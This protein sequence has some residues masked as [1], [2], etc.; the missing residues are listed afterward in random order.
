M[1]ERKGI[2]LQAGRHDPRCRSSRAWLRLRGFPGDTVP[3]LKLDGEKVQGSREIS[4]ALDRSQPEPPLFPSDPDERAAVEDAE[5]WG[6][7]VLQSMPR[8]ISWNALGAR[9]LGPDELRGGRQARGARRDRRPHRRRRS[10]P[11]R[12]AATSANDE[13]TRARPRRAARRARSRRR[14]DRRGVIGGDEPNAADFQI[15]PSIRLLMTM[16]DLRP[17]SRTGRPGSWRCGSSR[18]SPGTCRRCC[19]PEW[20]E[21]LRG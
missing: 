8:R 6:D 17:R 13:N 21:P 19:P 3:A 11:W 1:L 15:A 10:S 7:E 14:A 20:L 9:P 4:R 2:P 5:R 16:D 18:I 12:S